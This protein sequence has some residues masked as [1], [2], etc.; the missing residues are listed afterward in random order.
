M[1]SSADDLSKKKRELL[2][3]LDKLRR[4]AS[5]AERECRLQTAS[6]SN[7]NGNRGN[8]TEEAFLVRDNRVSNGPLGRS[9]CSFARTAHV[10]C[11]L[12]HGIVEIHKY[13]FTL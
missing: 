9:L 5:K 6:L 13:V 4:E 12:P 10:F 11:S 1:A 7:R 3:Q 2:G 8:V